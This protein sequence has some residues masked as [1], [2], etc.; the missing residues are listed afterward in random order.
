VETISKTK[1]QLLST[2]DYALFYL[3]ELGF[4]VF[5]LRSEPPKDRKKPVVSWEP[6]QHAHTTPA[7]IEK[8]FNENPNYNIA[9]ATGNISNNMIAVDID[10]PTAVILST[11]IVLIQYL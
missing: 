7:Q 5:V 9:V 11:S 6:Y 3:R 8:W 10:G 4:S 2:K 1:D